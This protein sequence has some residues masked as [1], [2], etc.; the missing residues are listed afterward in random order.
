MCGPGSV[1]SKKNNESSRSDKVSENPLPPNLRKLGKKTSK[2][3]STLYRSEK[4]VKTLKERHGSLVRQLKPVDTKGSFWSDRGRVNSKR[5]AEILPLLPGRGIDLKDYTITSIASYGKSNSQD[6]HEEINSQEVRVIMPRSSRVSKLRNRVLKCFTIFK[7][8]TIKNAAKINQNMMRGGKVSGSKSEVEGKVEDQIN[9]ALNEKVV[10]SS[11]DSATTSVGIVEYLAGIRS[12]IKL[13][14]ENASEKLGKAK[15]IL[16]LDR[17]V[18]RA[19]AL[20]NRKLELLKELEVYEQA[21][22]QYQSIQKQLGGLDEKLKDISLRIISLKNRIDNSDVELVGSTEDAIARVKIVRYCFS[23]IGTSLSVAAKLTP[24]GNAVMVAASAFGVSGG[25]QTLAGVLDVISLKSAFKSSMRSERLNSSLTN[26]IRNLNNELKEERQA[27][28]VKKKALEAAVKRLSKDDSSTEKTIY[29]L[30]SGRIV[31]ESSADAIE[32]ILSVPDF[33]TVKNLF[34]DLMCLFTA[35]GRRQDQIELLQAILRKQPGFTSNL[36]K[37]YSKVMTTAGYMSGAVA[38]SASLAMVLGAS[39]AVGVVAVASPVGLVFAATGAAAALGITGLNSSIQFVDNRRLSVVINNFVGKGR[40]IK[41]KLKARV[42]EKTQTQNLVRGSQSTSNSEEVSRSSKGEV[43]G[44]AAEEAIAD[45]GARLIQSDYGLAH[46]DL[47]SSIT[48]SNILPKVISASPR[49][50]LDRVFD[51]LCLEFSDILDDDK[52]LP[53]I[54]IPNNR[55]AAIRINNPIKQHEDYE[56]IWQK[57]LTVKLLRDVLSPIMKDETFEQTIEGVL[58]A[59]RVCQVD[60][61][62]GILAK[63]INVK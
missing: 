62:K 23:I 37:P 63:L 52:Y 34:R 60:V 45:K 47:F 18:K 32:N 44:N 46:Q 48:E 51:Q 28:S 29:Q 16:V 7:S 13:L 40:K 42:P 24:E 59:T 4:V 21:T 17:L 61:A 39:G 56:E 25:A 2:T 20:L 11:V 35:M 55:L 10:P 30:L 9:T 12:C 3:N 1:S 5:L 33:N 41:Q 8:D 54:S 14:R 38:G 49:G 43:P 27:I 50:V 6:V 31:T 22:Q 26:K 57:S 36:L 19:D 53:D 15:S 58:E